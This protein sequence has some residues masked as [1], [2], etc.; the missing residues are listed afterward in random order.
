MKLEP[1]NEIEIPISPSLI[2]RDDDLKPP[3]KKKRVINKLNLFLWFY[4]SE[5]QNCNYINE[6]KY[7]VL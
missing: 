4:F 2:E 1:C 6:S 7:P 3:P 5:F